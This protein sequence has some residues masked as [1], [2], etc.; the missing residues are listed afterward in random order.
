M[1]ADGAAVDTL[2]CPFLLSVEVKD[3]VA[4]AAAADPTA[5]EDLGSSARAHGK[6]AAWISCAVGGNRAHMEFGTFAVGSGGG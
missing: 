5:R 3:G 2:D 4:L 6:F 1:V